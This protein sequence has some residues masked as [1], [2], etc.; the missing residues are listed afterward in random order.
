MLRFQTEPLKL[1]YVM[2]TTSELSFTKSSCNLG[3]VNVQDYFQRRQENYNVTDTT[4]E[5]ERAK[6]FIDES[7]QPVNTGIVTMNQ[8]VSVSVSDVNSNI[9]LLTTAKPDC[10]SESYL[11]EFGAEKIASD[12][13]VA[14]LHQRAVEQAVSDEM[15]SF[16][17]SATAT[18]FT[19]NIEACRKRANDDSSDVV[20]SAAHT[21]DSG[22]VLCHEGIP[23]ND[24]AVLPELTSVEKIGFEPDAITATDQWPS[25]LPVVERRVKRAQSEVRQLLLDDNTSGM[26]RE[27]RRS[28]G[29]FHGGVRRKTQRSPLQRLR[30][31][32]NVRH[33][34]SG[35]HPSG[36]VN[37][38]GN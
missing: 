36:K 24:V 19:A 5:A 9:G 2:Y 32:V 13:K 18:R 4:V 25:R 11:K 23:Q 20:G 31:V 3:I 34:T 21:D 28:S 12:V 38:K 30:S 27:L 17:S 35:R 33:S 1:Y 22:S 26:K 29:H 15:F 8:L 16:V 14:P 6:Q 7:C 10:H 37:N